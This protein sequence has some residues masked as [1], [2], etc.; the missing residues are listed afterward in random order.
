MPEHT[1]CWHDS[2]RQ[3]LSM[4]PQYVQVCCHCGEV[5]TVRP[6]VIASFEG[7]GKYHP[8]NYIT[9]FKDD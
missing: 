9:G 2:G 6:E 7:H 3:L 1:H 4:P 5:K 8:Q